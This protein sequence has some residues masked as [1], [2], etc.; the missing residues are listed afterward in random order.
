MKIEVLHAGGCANCLSELGALRSAATA[1]DPAVDWRE[2]DIVQ[3]ID[4]A[5][6]LGV[7]RPPAVAI[8]GELVFPSLPRPDELAA[9]MKA[10]MRN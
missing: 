6:E 3:A 8:D 9:A 2:L 10:R 7:L 1:V 5:V 4:Y